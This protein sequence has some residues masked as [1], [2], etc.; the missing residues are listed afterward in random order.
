MYLGTQGRSETGW[1]GC[2]ALSRETLSTIA[3][4]PIL[5]VS[6]HTP[7]L[8]H[9]GVTKY[10]FRQLLAMKVGISRLQLVACLRAH[11]RLR[12]SSDPR[13]RLSTRKLLVHFVEPATFN[14]ADR[15]I[16]VSV[17]TSLQHQLIFQR[18]NPVVIPGCIPGHPTQ[19]ILPIL[20]LCSRTRHDLHTLMPPEVGKSQAETKR[21]HAQPP[22]LS[23]K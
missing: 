16:V 10:A 21:K 7:I 17:R 13:C 2:R 5:K 23:S 3:S 4:S 8:F 18:L 1:A 14:A 22:L 9:A 20:T 6:T 15:C 12:C 19:R 11:R